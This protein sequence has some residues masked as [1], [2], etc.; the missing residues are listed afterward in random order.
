M[1]GHEIAAAIRRTRD[2]GREAALILPVGPMGMYRWAVYFL[3]EWGVGCD[4]VHGFNMDEWSDAAGST[5]PADDPG[6]CQC[7]GE[8]AFYG[9][10]GRQPVPPA[11]RWFAT[12]DRLPHYAKRIA[13]LK[14]GG[15]E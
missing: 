6:A 9:R 12:P 7:A 10:L 14:S 5:L 1:L 11:H 3:K 15:A 8:A 13:E 2:Q 4:H